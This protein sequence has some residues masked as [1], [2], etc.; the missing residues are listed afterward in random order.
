MPA[1]RDTG[2]PAFNLSALWWCPAAACFVA[3]ALS[4][5]GSGSQGLWITAM[6]VLFPLSLLAYTFREGPS[7]AERPSGQEDRQLAPPAL[8]DRPRPAIEY[9][10]PR[11]SPPSAS[12]GSPPLAR[13]LHLLDS[14]EERLQQ[15]RLE[16]PRRR[17]LER[18]AWSPERKNEYKRYLRSD[19]WKQLRQQK[20][21]SAGH[22]CEICGRKPVKQLHHNRYPEDFGEERVSDLSA[23]CGDCHCFLH[24]IIPHKQTEQEGLAM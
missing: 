10:V 2:R 11:V 21:D 23:M 24:G 19:R 17:L 16:E 18:R 4:T 9:P 14:Q 7:A 1:K 6:F 12:L 8:G 22:W 15:R 20:L 5:P 3:A 13:R